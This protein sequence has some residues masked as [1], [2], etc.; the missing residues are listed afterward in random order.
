MATD[1]HIRVGEILERAFQQPTAA[2]EAFIARAARGSGTVLGEVKSLLSHYAAVR[3]F[4]LERPKGM[5]CVRSLGKN[6][7]DDLWQPPFSIAPFRVTEVLGCG[8]MGVVYRGVHSKTRAEVAIKVIRRRLLLNE[9]RRFKQEEELLRRLRHP[10]IVWF[11]YSGQVVIRRGPGRSVEDRRP[12]FVME[13]VAGMPLT[14]YANDNKLDTLQRLALLAR[15]CEAVQF[16]HLRGVVHCDLKPDNIL[17]DQSG[18][19]RILDFGIATLGQIRGEPVIDGGRFVGTPAYASPEQVS[20]RRSVLSPATDVYSLG[21]IA[22]ELLAGRLPRREAGRMAVDLSNVRTSAGHDAPSHRDLELQHA[23]RV[24][25]IAAL[26]G[27][28][29]RRYENAG[30]FGA[31]LIAVQRAFSE[32]SDRKNTLLGWLA[33]LRREAPSAPTSH[34][35]LLCALLRTR[36]GLGLRM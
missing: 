16:A 22:H 7:D 2:R 35:Q 11:M 18:Q 10:G 14:K 26:R 6:V 15:I 36:I 1:F 17:V 12:Y 5:P 31:D 33:G 3:R 29:G 34:D 13:Y 25:L 32:S 21:L 19:P 9:F 30:E 8:G 28:G 24:L 4:E 20:A 23:L 27:A